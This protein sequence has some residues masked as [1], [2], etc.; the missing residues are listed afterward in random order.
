MM[1]LLRLKEQKTDVVI[2]VN[3]PHVPGEYQPEDID[4]PAQKLGP[5]LTN[6]GTIRQKIF[7][8]FEIKDF[9]LFVNEEE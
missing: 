7:E 9:G 4:L 3:V 5:L 6:A 2:T 1:L 8:T